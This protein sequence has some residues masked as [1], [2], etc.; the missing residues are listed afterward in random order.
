MYKKPN[1]FI[2]VDGIQSKWKSQNTGIRQGCPL[3]P[4]LYLVVALVVAPVDDKSA[5][6]G[7]SALIVP[8][9]IFFAFF[10]WRASDGRDARGDGGRLKQGR[11]GLPEGGKRLG[12][13]CQSGDG[14]AAVRAV[15]L[16]N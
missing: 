11:H 8:A 10:A 4:L 14:G 15:S 3:S 1:F 2:E 7:L 16:P 12:R 5:V 9:C 13:R 6:A